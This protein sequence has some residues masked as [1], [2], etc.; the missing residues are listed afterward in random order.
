V[1]KDIAFGGGSAR[2]N[3]SAPVTAGSNG[4]KGFA[5]RDSSAFSARGG[6]VIRNALQG[7]YL[8]VFAQHAASPVEWLVDPRKLAVV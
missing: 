1:R 5:I 2:A 6:F 4:E 7:V 8:A 3:A